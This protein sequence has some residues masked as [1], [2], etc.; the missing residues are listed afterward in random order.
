MHFALT[1]D[2]A[3]IQDVTVSFAKERLLNYAGVSGLS[4]DCRNAWTCGAH[5]A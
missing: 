5:H 4:A 2:K 3:A 1:E